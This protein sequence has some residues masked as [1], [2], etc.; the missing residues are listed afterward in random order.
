MQVEH[1]AGI[2]L[3]ARRAAQ[4]QRHLAVGDGLLGEIVVEDDGVL[5]LSRKNSP[6]AQPV[7][8]AR[9]CIGAGSDAVAATTM[10]YSI[11]PCSSRVRTSWATVE[12]F[13]PMA[14]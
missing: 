5:P 13:W 14:T 9:N 2:G 11:A 1:V 8:G 4:Q 3:A 6:I 10:E 12:R 7:Y